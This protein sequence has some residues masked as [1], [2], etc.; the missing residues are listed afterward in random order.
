M[1]KIISNFQWNDTFYCV[2]QCP[3]GSCIELRSE[4]KLTEQEWIDLATTIY[5]EKP[6]EP[7]PMED[8]LRSCPDDMLVAEVLRRH[9][10]IK[11]G[12]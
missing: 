8:L 6:A 11:S 12:E 3:D 5:S 4:T 2:V 1:Y 10:I 9:L 7:D